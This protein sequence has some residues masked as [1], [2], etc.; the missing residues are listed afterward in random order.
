MDAYTDLWK[1]QGW[2]FALI[3]AVILGALGAAGILDRLEA[4]LER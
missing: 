4:P 1:D 3:V 2:W